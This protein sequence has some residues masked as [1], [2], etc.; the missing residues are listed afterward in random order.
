MREKEAEKEKKNFFEEIM[1]E[2]FPKLGNRF[3]NVRLPNKVNPK[4]PTPRH[5]MIK[6]SKV[7]DS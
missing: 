3:R 4:R 2:K 7:K 5:I 1:T 6:M